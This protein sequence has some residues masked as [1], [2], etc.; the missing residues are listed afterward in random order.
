MT[1]TRSLSLSIM[2]LILRICSA[3]A[4]V[5]FHRNFTYL[6][7]LLSLSKKFEF[8]FLFSLS[9]PT[10][11]SRLHKPRALAS[12]FSCVSCCS[13]VL[14]FRFLRTFFYEKA[15][16]VVI[17]FFLRFAKRKSLSWK[18][19]VFTDE[20]EKLVFSHGIHPETKAS[21]LT[22]KRLEFVLS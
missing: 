8:S 16:F 13:D 19:A 6:H 5:S 1:Y 7:I 11:R 17:A 9:V 2:D 12:V 20:V 10:P 15:A 4:N 18:H 14:R 22:G 21:V 3:F